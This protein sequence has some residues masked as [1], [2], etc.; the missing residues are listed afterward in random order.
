MIHSKLL[1]KFSGVGFA[2]RFHILY[3][4]GVVPRSDSGLEIP[5]SRGC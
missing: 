5:V 4:L 3:T 2:L 1:P